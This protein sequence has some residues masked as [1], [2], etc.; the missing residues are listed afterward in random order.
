[1]LIIFVTGVAD[2]E[3][4]APCTDDS[5]MRIASIS[6]SMTMFLL[7]KLLEQGKLDLDLPIDQYLPEDKFPKK[8]FAGKKV[9]ITLR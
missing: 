2:L 5:V 7:G 9:D 1:M 6:K 8:Y 4:Q 3:T